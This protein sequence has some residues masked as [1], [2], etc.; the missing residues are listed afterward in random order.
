MP[1]L[2]LILAIAL[3]AFA[4]DGSIQGRV[5][6]EDAPT[7]PVGAKVSLKEQNFEVAEDGTYLIPALRPGKYD[8]TVEWPEVGVQVKTDVDVPMDDPVLLNFVFKPPRPRIDNLFPPM[9]ERA[10]PVTITGEYF[11]HAGAAAMEVKIAG[12]TVPATRVSNSRIELSQEVIGNAWRAMGSRK[13]TVEVPVTVIINGISSN[14]ALLALHNGVPGSIEGRVTVNNPAIRPEGVEI[15][16]PDRATKLALGPNG[17]FSFSKVPPKKYAMILDWPG[18]GLHDEQTIEVFPGESSGVNFK[19]NIPDPE[20]TGVTPETIDKPQS[21]VVRGRFF[22]H[23]VKA[24]YEVR[25]GTR[26]VKAER[27][28]N[29]ILQIP[30]SE[31]AAYLKRVKP[32]ATE[33]VELSLL[34]AGVKS[35]PRKVPFKGAAEPPKVAAEPAKGEP[36]KAPEAA[37]ENRAPAATPNP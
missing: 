3:P 20:I 2:L 32:G 12:K 16:V 1:Y 18:L 29:Q 13:S 30:E 34:V 9:V 14:E 7:P 37:P 28:S 17:T 6:M 5:S 21:L 26:A 36:A 15:K 35:K 10:R 31:I 19:I 8:V 33:D 23:S 24:S 27:I 25:L 22:L 11:L 4:K